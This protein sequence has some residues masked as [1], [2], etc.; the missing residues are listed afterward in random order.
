MGGKGAREDVRGSV[1]R[2]LAV[3]I[4]GRMCQCGTP[5]TRRAQ[6]AASAFNARKHC[7]A[8]CYLASIRVSLTAGRKC[9]CG[10]FLVKRSGE[11]RYSFARRKFC[12]QKH[13]T[14]DYSPRGIHRPCN[15]C[16]RPLVKKVGE[17]KRDFLRR[18]SCDRA[19][20][21]AARRFAPELGRQCPCGKVL[22][23]HLEGSRRKRKEPLGA[24]SKR[25]HCSHLCARFYRMRQVTVMGVRLSI[26]ELSQITKISRSALSQ[27]A[28]AHGYDLSDE[29]QSVRSASA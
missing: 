5:L 8:E 1:S 19:C 12:N 15:S 10:K 23:P 27:R 14:V 2:K 13:S 29:L 26:P 22:V 20:A 16:R 7:H 25:R 18:K 28:R 17:G 11:K 24:F 9:P 21:F 6:E 4:I 3:P